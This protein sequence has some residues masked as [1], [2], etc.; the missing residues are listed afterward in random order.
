M[1]LRQSNGLLDRCDFT[2][3]VVDTNKRA[4][5]RLQLLTKYRSNGAR[6]HVVEGYRHTE[7][8]GAGRKGVS[9]VAEP[10]GSEL[11]VT[12]LATSLRH[13]ACLGPR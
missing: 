5:H 9:S 10:V 7:S 1:Q 11:A 3:Q 13:V 12:Y 8:I 2:K 4:R 6:L